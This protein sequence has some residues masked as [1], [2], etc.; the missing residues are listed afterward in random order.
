MFHGLIKIETD[1]EGYL[2]GDRGIR[3][4]KGEPVRTAELSFYGLP[5]VDE[6]IADIKEYKRLEEEVE[7]NSEINAWLDAGIVKEETVMLK[8]PDMDIEGTT[9]KE[10]REVIKITR[11]IE[12]YHLGE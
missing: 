11:S 12:F 10:P 1:G 2:V 8:L 4:K 9:I 6:T 3:H 7:S 5:F